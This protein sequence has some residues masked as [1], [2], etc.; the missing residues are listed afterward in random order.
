MTDH[1]PLIADL[2]SYAPGERL[3]KL[4]CEALAAAADALESG[5]LAYVA[6]ETAGI[7][8]QYER[9]AADWERRVLLWQQRAEATDAKLVKVIDALRSNSHEVCIE[10][11][12]WPTACSILALRS[13]VALAGIEA[14]K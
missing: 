14:M 10:R 5:L 9:R 12:G 11:T 1:A 2:R 4:D 8:A 3:T 6:R 13:R 7:N